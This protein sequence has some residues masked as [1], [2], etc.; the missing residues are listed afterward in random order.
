MI[1]VRFFMICLLNT[2]GADGA[3]AARRADRAFDGCDEYDGARESLKDVRD[4]R[5][6]F[7]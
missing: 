6:R 5:Q 3:A 1:P 4:T 7:E 2:G